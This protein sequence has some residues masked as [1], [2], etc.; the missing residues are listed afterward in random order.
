MERALDRQF[1]KDLSMGQIFY[2]LCGRKL[3]SIFFNEFNIAA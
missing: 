3:I 2:K 1:F